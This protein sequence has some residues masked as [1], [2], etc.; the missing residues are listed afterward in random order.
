MFSSVINF[1]FS[2]SFSSFKLYIFNSRL[3]IF[4]N[5][6]S[7]S[8]L[9]FSSNSW[10]AVPFFISSIKLFNL[11]ISF[12]FEIFISFSF[13]ISLSFDINSPLYSS[14]LLFSSIFSKITVILIIIFSSIELSSSFFDSI[15]DFKKFDASDILSD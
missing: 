3:L 1:S 4:D 7:F 6:C 12:S 10:V 9:K 11:F 13:E 5:N 14:N 2:F 8:F 15:N